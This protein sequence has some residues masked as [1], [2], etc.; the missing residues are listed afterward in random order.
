MLYQHLHEDVPPPSATVPGMAYALDE[1]V[2]AATAR[3]PEIR[4]AD[5]V[6][7]LGQVLEA[8]AGLTAEQLDAVPPGALSVG[9]DNADDRTSVIPRSLS[10]PRLLPVNEDDSALDRTS[11]FEQSS[12]FTT[13][14]VGP[15]QVPGTRPR[16]G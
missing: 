1:L 11:R 6:S 12:P 4:P 13:A 3:N 9:H 10:V 5:A 2:T 16:R 15:P 8:R 14:P 7:L